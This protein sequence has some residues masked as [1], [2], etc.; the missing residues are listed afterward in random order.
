MED[1][2]TDRLLGDLKYAFRRLV[3]EPRFAVVTILILATGVAASTVMFSVVEAVLLRPYNIE[4]P[5]RVVVMWPVQHDLPG[6][7]TYNAARDLR[8]LESL[9][10]AASVSSTN[11]WGTISVGDART[12]GVPAR[13]YRRY[14]LTCWVPALSSD[15][16][17]GRG[18]HPPPRAC[19]F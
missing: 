16:L 1:S 2:W 13:S 19:S 8:R 3:R 17:S 11:W 18:D 7:F 10:S 14:F 6:E 9:E 15:A 5:A 12:V 4:S